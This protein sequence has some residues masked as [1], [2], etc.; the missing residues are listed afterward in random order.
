MKENKKEKTCK[1][2]DKK[3]NISHSYCEKHYKEILEQYENKLSIYNK[4]LEE[5][6]RKSENEKKAA[7][8]E[9]EDSSV[10]MFHLFG[11]IVSLCVTGWANWKYVLS[12]KESYVY[13]IQ[14][15]IDLASFSKE[16]MQILVII[17]FIA[18]LLIIAVIMKKYE[19]FFG[20]VTR[21]LFHSSIKFFIFFA[22]LAVG[23]TSD[24]SLTSQS[25]LV[26]AAAISILWSTISEL[27]G[28]HHASAAPIK[29]VRP[30]H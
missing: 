24:K 14:E 3:I 2:C 13:K 20:R 8:S 21:V 30:S 10:A 15:Y 6:N 22:M 19:Y 5:W 7:H 23:A 25:Y 18:P 9:A 29:P 4:Q 1:R 11:M 12:N 17:L 27:R 28:G 16:I 26:G